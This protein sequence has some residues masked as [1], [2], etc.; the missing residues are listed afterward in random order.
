MNKSMKVLSLMLVITML[1]ITGCSSASSQVDEKTDGEA[2]RTD[3]IMAIGSEGASMDPHEGRSGDISYNMVEGLTHQTK[4]LEIVPCIAKSW[5]I[6]DDKLEYVFDID[7]SMKFANG[8]NITP[9]DVKFSLERAAAEPTNESVVVDA[10]DYLEV[11]DDHTIKLVLKYPCGLV[12]SDLAEF[13][14]GIISKKVVEEAGDDY[15]INPRGSGSGPYDFVSWTQGVNVKLEANPYYYEDLAIKN[16][17]VRFITEAST[18]V[19]SVEAGDI[20]AYTKPAYI[21]AVNLMDSDTVSVYEYDKNGFDFLGFNTQNPPYND[22]RV[23]QAIAYSYD[24]E[25][26]VQA[27]IGKG[28]AT[29]ADGFFQDFVLGY[30]PNIKSYPHDPEKAKALLKEA[31]YPDGLEINI[32]TMDGARAKVAEYLQETMKASGFTVNIEMAEWSKF[33]QDLIDGNLETFII[34]VVGTLPDADNTLFTQFVTGSAANVHAYSDERVDELLLKARQS[35]DD[36]ERIKL[37]EEAQLILMED[38]PCIPLY[39]SKGYVIVN[40][41]LQGFSVTLETHVRMKDLSWK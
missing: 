37:Y 14:C 35:S 31:G 9:E 28:G 27:A 19:I 21:D 6:S 29:A 25:E 3:F 33:V 20:D 34:G 39:F 26:L 36:E 23:R 38:L 22:P 24:N 15:S 5:T 4:D 40:P 17:D 18:G 8:D 13:K 1:F 11:L 2:V 41:D 12:L 30:S 7:T 10:L 32:V 16:I